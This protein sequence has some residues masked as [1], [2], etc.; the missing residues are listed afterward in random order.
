MRSWLRQFFSD[1]AFFLQHTWVVMRG[2]EDPDSQSHRLPV[3]IGALI[4]CSLMGL[5]AV[6]VAHHASTFRVMGPVMKKQEPLEE[7]D[8]TKPVRPEPKRFRARTHLPRANEGFASG[9][10]NP[11]VFFPKYDLVSVDDDRV[12]WESEHDRNDTEDDH[13]MHRSLEE[14]FRRLV[15]LTVQAGGT[16]KVQDTYRPSGIHARKSLHR[17]GRAIDVTCDELG[18]EKLAKLCWAAG[19][20]WVY[21][22]APRRGGAHVH[23]SVRHTR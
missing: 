15:E 20:D 14:P 2:R 10:L 17:E 16:L 4:S 7:L 5:T 19:F 22:E 9:P 6:A 3:L 11:K 13:V 12:W 18:L 8:L 1:L 21:Y 23:C